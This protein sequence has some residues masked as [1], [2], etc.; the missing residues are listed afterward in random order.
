MIL[1]LSAKTTSARVCS[2]AAVPAGVSSTQKVMNQSR[3]WKMISPSKTYLF[4]RQD[5]TASTPF[6]ECTP[7]S[8]GCRRAQHALPLQIR[9]ALRN[10]GA[11]HAVPS[12]QTWRTHSCV[13]SRHSWRH[14]AGASDP[15]WL[16]LRLKP[17]TSQ[18][19][20]PSHYASHPFPGNLGRLG[21]PTCFSP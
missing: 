17:T 21:K 14:R 15:T 13:P 18:A 5:N 4:Y 8:D 12:V 19:P 10:V 20:F 3:L 11:Q 2:V 6:H 7:I 1:K 9:W 16:A